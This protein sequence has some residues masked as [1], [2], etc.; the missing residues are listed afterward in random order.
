MVKISNQLKEIH[1]EIDKLGD[2]MDKTY[3]NIDK[4]NK[5]VNSLH[6]PKNKV[7]KFSENFNKL[8]CPKGALF[9]TIRSHNDEKE[10]YYK[11]A[12]GEIFQV[13]VNGIVKFHARLLDVVNSTEQN[14]K[15]YDD[16]LSYDTDNNKDWINRIKNLKHCL[17]LIFIKGE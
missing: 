7:I 15:I 11:N 8:N 10:H 3:E 2:T 6:K 17:I 1:V 9:S 5:F 4:I 13:E 14:N 12:I 16:F